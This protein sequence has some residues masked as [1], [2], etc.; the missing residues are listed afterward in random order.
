MKIRIAA[1]LTAATALAAGAATAIPAY[2]TATATDPSTTVHN[3]Q[4]HPWDIAVTSSLGSSGALS[5]T[6]ATSKPF[7]GATNPTA[8]PAGDL[9]ARW[10]LYYIPDGSMGGWKLCKNSDPGQNWSFSSVDS[11]KYTLNSSAFKSAAQTACGDGIY[12]LVADGAAFVN[13]DYHG[14]LNVFSGPVELSG[15]TPPGS[16]TQFFA[17]Q[18]NAAAAAA[19]AGAATAHKGNAAAAATAAGNAAAAAAASP[20]AKALAIAQAKA[21]VS[22]PPPL[23]AVTLP[24]RS[25]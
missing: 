20:S 25:K 7:G 3:N 11:S 24:H 5:A 2:A 4:F 9:A 21:A 19:A 18:P 22:V 12:G 23:K 14:V 17:K 6:A 15:S 10:A 13:G 16:V 8:V 1:V